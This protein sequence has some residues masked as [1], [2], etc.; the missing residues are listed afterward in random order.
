LHSRQPA[1]G[2]PASALAQCHAL[3]SRGVLLL[4][5]DAIAVLVGVLAIVLE[6]DR[7]G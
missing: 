6:V 1:F 7:A 2:A 5:Q 4:R 3:S